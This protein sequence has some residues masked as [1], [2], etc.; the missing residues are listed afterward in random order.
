MG[1]RTS[2]WPTCST[3]RPCRCRIHGLPIASGSGC[4]PKRRFEPGVGPDLGTTP[5]GTSARSVD[6]LE[7]IPADM[8]DRGVCSS[9]RAFRYSD[10]CG[11][12]RPVATSRCR[13][14][15]VGSE[16]P[17][18]E[19]DLGAG[20]CRPRP[21][22]RRDRGRSKGRPYLVERRPANPRPP[23]SKNRKSSFE[24]PRQ[25]SYGD[26]IGRTLKYQVARRR[27]D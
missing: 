24:T 12:S 4:G 3:C 5:V 16:P 11:S 10:A 26:P 23:G 8:A 25:F 14:D 19:G 27:T 17:P 13:K 15:R 6:L 22:R 18:R 21:S 1:R 7:Q 20:N 2:R 9:L